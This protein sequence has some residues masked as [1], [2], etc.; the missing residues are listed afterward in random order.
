MGSVCKLLAIA[1]AI[2]TAPL[3]S[4]A[5]AAS[6]TV[7][8]GVVVVRGGAKAVPDT[9]RKGFASECESAEAG[10]P[11]AAYKVARRYLFGVGVRKN[12]RVGTAWLRAAATR[13]HPEARKLVRYIP[14]RMG[15]IRPYCRPGAAPPRGLV[16]PPEE[17]V[18]MVE[19]MAPTYGLDPGL[20]LAVVQVESAFRTDAVSP[21]EAAGLMQLIPDTAERFDVRDSSNPEDNLRGG[22]KYLRWLLAYF[23]GDVRLALAGY[24]AGE[25]AVDRHR[26]IPPYEETRAYVELIRRLYPQAG[27]PF[28]PA[29]AEPSPHI[30]R[31]TAAL[32][33]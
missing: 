28:D 20:V 7:D 6:R 33:R 8:H 12:K 27:H 30:P 18:R 3:L 10:D 11:Q 16:A 26:G 2:L 17:I 5:C 24:N 13:G 22:M 15:H 29:A 14:G 32:P 25:G 21:K 19:A 23:R 9:M 1:L 31:R 4:D